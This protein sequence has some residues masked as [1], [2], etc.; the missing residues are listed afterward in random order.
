MKIKKALSTHDIGNTVMCDKCG[1]DYS[2]SDESG[3]FLFGSYAYCPKCAKEE[4]EG[5]REY[6]EEGHIRA[7]CPDGK[8]FRDWILGDIRKG[9]N[10]IK[11]Y[12]LD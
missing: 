6:R 5:I 4:I 9:D 12:S 2:N 1:E 10:T 8:S 7:Y 3:G 11:V